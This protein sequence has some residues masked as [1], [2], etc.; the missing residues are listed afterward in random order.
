MAQ[1][2]ARLEDIHDVAMALPEVPH[3]EAW[4]GR[5][6]Y[7]VRG[8][9]FLFFREPRKDA[10]DPETGERMEDVIVFLTPSQE[11]KE[12]LLQAGPPWFTTGH[13]DGYD[14]VLLRERDISRVSRAELEEVICDAWLR[15]APKRLAK[16]WLAQHRPG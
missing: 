13:F 8:K 10:V 3:G 9:G 1:R 2:R 7:A 5:R 11:D 12:A 14:A 16:E 15:R 4:G 6:A